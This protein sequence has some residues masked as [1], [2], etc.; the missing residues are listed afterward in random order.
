MDDMYI[1]FFAGLGLLIL[2][3]SHYS[4]KVENVTNSRSP[5][6]DTYIVYICYLEK[7]F[8]PL[9]NPVVSLEDEDYCNTF[10]C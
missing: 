7:A 3:E 5:C 2:D 9:S 6:S 1:S 4:K 10:K 8:L